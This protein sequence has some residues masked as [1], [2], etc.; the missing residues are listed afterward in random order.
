MVCVPA[1]Q[2]GGGEGRGAVAATARGAPRLVPSSVNW[3]VPLVDGVPPVVTV[4]VKVTAS[5]GRRRVV[6]GGERGAVGAHVD[7]LVDAV[8][9][10]GEGLVPV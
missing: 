1:V 4:A 6:V 8:G 9:A 5:P 3:T 2:C 10:V 7:D